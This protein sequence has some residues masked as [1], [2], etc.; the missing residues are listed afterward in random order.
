[1]NRGIRVQFNSAIGPFK[2]GSDFDPKGITPE[3][4]EFVM[5]LKNVRRGRIREYA[6]KFG[7]EYHADKRP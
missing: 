6:D 3:K 7:A 4:L 5:H 2:G 1:M